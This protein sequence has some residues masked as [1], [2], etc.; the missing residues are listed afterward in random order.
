M[1]LPPYPPVPP[2][3][4]RW[5]RFTL[6]TAGAAVAAFGIGCGLAVWGGDG[7]AP[8]AA[9]CKTALTEALR[10][11]MAD[12]AEAAPVEQPAACRGL[13]VATMERV[14]GEVFADA[15]REAWGSGWPSP[16]P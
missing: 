7:G 2:A 16:S 13:S 10:E 6:W 9:A 3:R 5:G 8:D 11:G 1:S 4:P 14:G 12:G 15:W